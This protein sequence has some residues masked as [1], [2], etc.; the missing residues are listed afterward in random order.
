MGDGM[1]SMD[2]D[3]KLVICEDCEHYR[4]AYS[5]GLMAS[6]GDICDYHGELMDKIE[7][8]SKWKEVKATC[9]IC[10]KNIYEGDT[11]WGNNQIGTICEECAKKII[12]AWLRINSDTVAWNLL[13]SSLKGGWYREISSVNFNDKRAVI[14]AIK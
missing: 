2:I 3:N 8:C 6:V 9:F 4:T 14:S 13:L 12:S 10:E 1:K 5:P 11:V 7:S